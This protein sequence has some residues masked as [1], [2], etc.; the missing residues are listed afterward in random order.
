MPDG[1]IVTAGVSSFQTLGDV[2]VTCHDRPDG[3]LDRRIRRTAA[4]RSIDY[5]GYGE[6]GL[7]RR[8]GRRRQHPRRRRRERQW[9]GH[10]QFELLRVLTPL[11]GHVVDPIAPTTPELTVDEGSVFPLDVTVVDPEGD[12]V[13][14]WTVDWGDGSDP[15]NDTIAD[16][17]IAAI[18][19]HGNGAWTITH[20][21]ADDG[22]YTV[23]ITVVDE[24][25]ASIDLD[26]RGDGT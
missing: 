8:R 19:D 12:A 22:D 6:V 3:G 17:W 7:Q 25:G 24:H 14:G 26:G 9:P 5:Q 11:S 2:A 13:A 16:G 21:Y 15:T 18:T 1:R 4:G 20:T 10:I 23:T